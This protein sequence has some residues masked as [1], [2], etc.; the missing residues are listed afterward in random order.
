[1]PLCKVHFKKQNGLL[2]P[3]FQTKKRTLCLVFERQL[4]QC[5]LRLLCATLASGQ[6]LWLLFSQCLPFSCK[7]TFLLMLSSRL[8]TQ[9]PSSFS[10]VLFVFFPPVFLL[11]TLMFMFPCSVLFLS[12]EFMLFL[13]LL[14]FCP[15]YDLFHSLFFPLNS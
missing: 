5:N 9:S 12:F 14:F 11:S 3:R 2:Q 8:R 10:F 4:P 1:M 6:A 15:T 7:P 13:S